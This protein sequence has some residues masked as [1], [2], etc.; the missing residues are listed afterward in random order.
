MSKDPNRFWWLSLVLVVACTGA[1]CFFERL[2]FPASIGLAGG[3]IGFL[4]GAALAAVLEDYLD[5]NL[6]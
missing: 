3:V 6:K 2:T 1:F 4:L 5:R